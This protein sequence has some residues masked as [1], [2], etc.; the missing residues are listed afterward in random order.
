MCHSES[1]L[2]SR[3][4]ADCAAAA[5]DDDDDEA[6]VSLPCSL[7]LSLSLSLSAFLDLPGVARHGRLWETNAAVGWW[8]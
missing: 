7:P 3:C 6:E 8:Q 4:S 5:V 1:Y 2:A